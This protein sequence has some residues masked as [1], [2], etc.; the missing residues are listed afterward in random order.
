MRALGF[1][2]ACAYAALLLLG[3]VLD[4]HAHDPY[5]EH[6]VLRG[7]APAWTAVDSPGPQHPA[8]VVALH[9]GGFASA[10]VHAGTCSAAEAPAPVLPWPSPGDRALSAGIAH[11]QPVFLDPPAPPPRAS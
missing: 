1:R 8:G 5:H 9:A 11:P 2:V 4:P 3:P 7:S 6:L 10:V